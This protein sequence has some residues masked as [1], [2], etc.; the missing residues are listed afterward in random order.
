M[1]YTFYTAKCIYRLPL[2]A[3]IVYHGSCARAVKYD[4][5]VSAFRDKRHL[6]EVP[7][8]VGKRR[9]KFCFAAIRL[10][11]DMKLLGN[12]ACRKRNL[13]LPLLTLRTLHPCGEDVLCA[14]F[15]RHRRGLQGLVLVAGP[16]APHAKSPFARLRLVRYRLQG[17]AGL[18]D[19]VPRL[20]TPP[21]VP[22]HKAKFE[23]SVR[24]EVA[25]RIA[26]DV[27]RIAFPEVDD[28]RVGSGGVGSGGV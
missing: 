27:H 11:H 24:E 28:A 20:A 10:R 15:Q 7:F 4:L 22:V 16:G 5:A 12:R 26:R 19:Y 14:R 6:H 1:F 13:R 2:H 18:R 25:R 17:P 9:N 3:N 23:T 21:V 8:V